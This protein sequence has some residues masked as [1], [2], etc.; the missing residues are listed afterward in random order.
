MDYE[1]ED[2]YNEELWSPFDVTESRYYQ[3]DYENSS[4]KRVDDE[5][6]RAWRDSCLTASEELKKQED[7]KKLFTPFMRG[8]CDSITVEDMN[9]FMRNK[10]KL[11]FM[12]LMEG[13]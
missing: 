11:E 12:E 13:L 3:W 9:Q 4:T 7:K 5:I 8:Y 10:R 1:I 2:W 6:E